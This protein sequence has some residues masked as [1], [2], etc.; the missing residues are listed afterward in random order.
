M[1]VCSFTYMDASRQMGNPGLVV[2][3]DAALLGVSMVD[4]GSKTFLYLR[5]QGSAANQMR[6]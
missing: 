3:V 5:L 2:A 1:F 6:K 4:N